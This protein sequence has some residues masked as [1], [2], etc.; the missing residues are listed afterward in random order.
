LR[1][2]GKK[3]DGGG[4]GAINAGLVFNYADGTFSKGKFLMNWPGIAAKYGFD[5]NKFCGPYVMSYR[6]GDNKHASKPTRRI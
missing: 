6:K 1:C 2:H 3:V 5:A 4:K